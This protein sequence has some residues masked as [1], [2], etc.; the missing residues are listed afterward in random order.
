LSGYVQPSVN[1]P[2]M[3]G[4]ANL[5]NWGPSNREIHALLL[6]RRECEQCTTTTVMN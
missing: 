1:N 2:D 6:H 5:L 4:T 3:D